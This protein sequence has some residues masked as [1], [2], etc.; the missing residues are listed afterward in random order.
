MAHRGR[1]NVLANILRQ[2]ASRASSSE[3]EEQHRPRQPRGRRRRQVPPR[4]AS[5]SFTAPGRPHG[6]VW[7]WPPTPATSRPSTRWSRAWPA[8]AR[9]VRGDAGARD[10]SCRCS[11]TAT[12]RSPARASSPRRSTSRQLAGYRTGGTVHIVVNNQI[13]FTTA[14]GRR[15]LLALLHRRRQDGRG[16]DLPRQRRRPRGR[17]PRSSQL[18]LEFRS[19]FARTSSS[20]W[21]ATAA[22]ATT[23]AT[24]RRS[25]SR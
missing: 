2:T 17:A 7:R 5:A 22:T 24:S 6:R 19:E 16:P 25:P 12:P 21:S 20:T 1:L 8:R 3:F 9:S 10:A 4:R 15:P 18:A 23:R 14:P 13:G 11:S